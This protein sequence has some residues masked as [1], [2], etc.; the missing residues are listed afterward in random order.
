MRFI[1]DPGDEPRRQSSAVARL[2]GEMCRQSGISV[3]PGQFDGMLL[4]V[5]AVEV[6]HDL[7]AGIAINVRLRAYPDMT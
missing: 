3:P 4:R 5:Q 6:E 1:E 2:L 7:E